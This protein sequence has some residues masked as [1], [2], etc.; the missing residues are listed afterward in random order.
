VCACAVVRP[1]ARDDPHAAFQALV[2]AGVFSEPFYDKG[3]G[4]GPWHC[5]AVAMEPLVTC[6]TAGPNPV[7]K[8]ALGKPWQC[9]DWCL[10]LHL[11][12][13]RCRCGFNHGVE[14]M[15][16][17]LPVPMDVHKGPS[18]VA[19]LTRRLHEAVRARDEEEVRALLHAGAKA[20]MSDSRGWNALHTACSVR[21]KWTVLN[22]LLRV[23]S[24]T[25]A[26]TRNSE[27]PC[28]IADAASNDDV[29]TKIK[30][31]MQQN[32]FGRHLPQATSVLSASASR[33]LGLTSLDND[34]AHGMGRR[35]DA[36]ESRA[37]L[38]DFAR[39]LLSKYPDSDAAFRAFDI[40][41][42]G[43]LT[44][45]EFTY[46]VKMMGYQG[47]LVSLFKALDIDRL[48]N[49]SVSEFAELQRIHTP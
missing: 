1:L 15:R 17:Q 14:I 28:D 8:P 41:N 11:P 37:M 42:N 12:A 9:Q 4:E 34:A 13:E 19:N 25:C 20:S 29:S 24:D 6:V 10:A 31:R 36:A 46:S 2:D 43:S 26:R 47:D 32:K 5:G 38:K 7:P 40:N 30:Q 21:P 35:K 27:L 49:V 48:G 45:S 39:E 23:G 22:Q 16:P 33:L 18:S 44:Q 3:S